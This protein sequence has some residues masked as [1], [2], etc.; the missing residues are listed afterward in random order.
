MKNIIQ[1]IVGGLLKPLC[2]KSVS[3]SGLCTSICTSRV[4]DL[5]T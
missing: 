3:Q 5:R 4:N 2:L 1:N